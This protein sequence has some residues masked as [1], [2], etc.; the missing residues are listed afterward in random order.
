MFP[1]MEGERFIYTDVDVFYH[2]DIYGLH[3]I[4]FDGKSLIVKNYYSTY[5]SKI[6]RKKSRTQHNMLSLMS[7]RQHSK[8]IDWLKQHNLPYPYYFNAGMFVANL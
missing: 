3:S 4:P 8:F 6:L 1:D 5:V 2:S 7:C